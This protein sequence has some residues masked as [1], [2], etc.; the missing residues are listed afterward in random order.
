[1]PSKPDIFEFPTSGN[2][3]VADAKTSDVRT[4]AKLNTQP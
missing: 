2:K 4:I 3:N 1:M